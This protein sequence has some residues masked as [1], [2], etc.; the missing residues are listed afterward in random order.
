MLIRYLFILA[1]ICRLFFA[2]PIETSN[3]DFGSSDLLI[4]VKPAISPYLDDTASSALLVQ[5]SLAMPKPKPEIRS[6]PVQKARKPTYTIT[7]SHRAKISAAWTKERRERQSLLFRN[8]LL[9]QTHSTERKLKVSQALMGRTT[10]QEVREKL[11]QASLGK[12]KSEATKQK[13]SESI[14][15]VIQRKK[16]MLQIID[17]T[18][19]KDD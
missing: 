10:K 14:K 17:K 16:E 9:G 12:R 8:R 4:S 11:R 13:I 19:L 2:Y 7:P 18:P 1:C 5:Q 6:P 15:R 3:S